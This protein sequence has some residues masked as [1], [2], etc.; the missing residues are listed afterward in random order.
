MLFGFPFANL[1]LRMVLFNTRI[2]L[3]CT[4]ISQVFTRKGMLGQHSLRCYKLSTMPRMVL[5]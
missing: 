2:S 4:I 3:R 1:F 5:I